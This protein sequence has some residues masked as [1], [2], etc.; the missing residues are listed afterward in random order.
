MQDI[1]GQ[2]LSGTSAQTQPDPRP[3]SAS[4]PILILL[5]T[6]TLWGT[7][8]QQLRSRGPAACFGGIYKRKKIGRPKGWSR[9]IRPTSCTSHV[10][11]RR[12]NE[13]RSK[14]YHYELM[15]MDLVY[16][17]SIEQMLPGIAQQKNCPQ[18]PQTAILTRQESN[19]TPKKNPENRPQRARSIIT[20]VRVPR[21]LCKRRCQLSLI[22]RIKP[23]SG[24]AL[25]RKSV[26]A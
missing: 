4:T 19:K 14:Q 13:V 9:T 6:L 22:D 26:T 2:V 1:C 8:G 5:L 18:S 16:D 17:L 25:R 3:Y 11:R 23:S 20:Y 24:R 15:E 21:S 10:A 7:R 12:C